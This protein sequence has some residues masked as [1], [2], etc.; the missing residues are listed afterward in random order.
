M[1]KSQKER[2]EMLGV[3]RQSINKWAKELPTT[4]CFRIR[5]NL[6]NHIEKLSEEPAGK[7]ELI[8][9]L[10]ET[11]NTIDTMIRKAKYLPKV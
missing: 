6:A 4:Q 2:S 11:L 5:K 7:E 10:V 3:S 9:D 8:V 1:G